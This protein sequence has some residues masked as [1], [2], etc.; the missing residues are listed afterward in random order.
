M[1][2]L[3]II[4]AYSLFI[5]I[6]FAKTV[7][8]DSEKNENGKVSVN[9]QNGKVQDRI[10]ID[11]N[12]DMS[13]SIVIQGQHKRK[14][15]RNVAEGFISAHDSKYISTEYEEDL[16]DFKSFIISVEGKDIISWTAETAW[17]D[18][19]F[20]VNE[21][22]AKKTVIDEEKHSSAS[23]L[24]EWKSLLDAGIITQEEFNIKKKQLLGL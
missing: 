23:E 12:T 11:N 15:I 7:P 17:S 3:I 10:H 4:I 24:L 6:A 1:K 8:L 9:N 13:I 18:L 20:S 22:S 19:F 21:T 2:K 14:G 16:D 5:S